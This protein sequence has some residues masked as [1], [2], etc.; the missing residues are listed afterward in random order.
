[1]SERLG[2]NDLIIQPLDGPEARAWLQRWT[3]IV[4]GQVAPI[5]MSMFGDWYLRRP[6]GTTDELS[7][8]EGTCVRVAS[9][10]E[11]FW[12]LVNAQAWQEDHLLSWLVFDLHQ[13]GLIPKAG[14]CYGFAPHP[15]ISGAIKAEH[16]MVMQIGAWQSICAQLVA[17]S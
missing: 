8:I 4:S 11:E 15:L 6:D 7:V 10:Y 16:A 13:R 2:W 5:L 3:G 12:S 1:M 9:T 17:S 14:Q